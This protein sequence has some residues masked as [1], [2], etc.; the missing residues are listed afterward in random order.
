M[1][2]YWAEVFGSRETRMAAL[3]RNQQPTAGSSSIEAIRKNLERSKSAFCGATPSLTTRAEFLLSGLMG[4]ITIVKGSGMDVEFLVSRI[5]G[6]DRQ[7]FSIGP[8][9]EYLLSGVFNL[10]ST[11]PKV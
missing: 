2:L 9:G 4:D 5:F 10:H 7:F 1:Q 11:Q 3:T 8:E 6:I